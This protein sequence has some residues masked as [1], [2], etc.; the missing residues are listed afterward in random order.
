VKSCES[1]WQKLLAN[2][3]KTVELRSIKPFL[4]AS[5]MKEPEKVFPPKKE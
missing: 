2:I 4:E 5:G 3:N 1:A